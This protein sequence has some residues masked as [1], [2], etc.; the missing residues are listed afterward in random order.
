LPPL[1]LHSVHCRPIAV[2]ARLSSFMSP[3]DLA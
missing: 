2:F 3:I 1:C